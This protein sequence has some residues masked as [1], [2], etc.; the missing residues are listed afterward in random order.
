M[1]K[2]MK[3]IDE[4]EQLINEIKEKMKNAIES[5]DSETFVKA[6][7]ELVN[8]I[9]ES[10]L[11][12]AKSVANLNDQKV[13]AG[14]GM[15]P[16]TDAELTYYNEVIGAEGF[17]G[18]EKLVPPTV[19]ERVFDELKQKRPLLSVIDFKN[20]TG[21]IDWIIRNN[22]VEAAWWGSLTG[23][24]E[25][26]LSMAF[27][28]ENT[29]VFKLSAFLPVSKSMLKL[30]PNW[31]DKFVRTVLFESLSLALE[32]AIVAGTGKEQPIGML[33]DLDGSVVGGVYPD[34]TA[35]EIIDLS[36]KTL[37]E[38][39]MSP[40]TK[41]GKRVVEKTI[42][43]VNPLDYWS[44]IFPSTTVLTQ[45]GTYAYGVLP[46]P[47]EVIQSVAVPSGKM[48]AGVARDYFMG[49]GSTGKVEYSDH[50]KFLED[51][52]TYLTKQY[53]NGKP[54]DNESFIVF[55]ISGVAAPTL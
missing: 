45:N 15:N 16:L 39:I 37:G 10:I 38:K 20:T 27:K 53:A 4:Q 49:V 44:K 51:E 30:G 52:R 12:E 55:D 31:L 41:N 2:K 42:L 29:N 34:K 26:K 54:V 1:S 7:L 9:E 25:K 33:K 40:L 35:V 28:K 14:R 17:G 50:Y 24:I 19:F 32:I 5:N 18:V 48:I 47:A 8:N 43:V 21:S 46:I 3:N 13:L 11:E 36:P 6:Q 22:D 23:E